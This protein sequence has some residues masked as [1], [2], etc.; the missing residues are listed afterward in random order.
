MY[1]SVVGEG[2]GAITGIGGGGV[3]GGGTGMRRMVAETSDM[4][5]TGDV[6]AGGLLA[7]DAGT[8]GFAAGRGASSEA[9]SCGVGA[10][11]GMPGVCELGGVP[12][13]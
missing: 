4:E 7:G 13:G 12:A 6:G 9:A 11:G 2:V 10:H 8:G 5:G 3:E 1:R